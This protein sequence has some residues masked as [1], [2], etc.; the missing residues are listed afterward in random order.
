MNAVIL[1]LL[2]WCPRPAR[3]V[4]K[5]ESSPEKSRVPRPRDT[6][7]RETS[8]PGSEQER[9]PRHPILWSEQAWSLRTGLKGMGRA[10]PCPPVQPRRLRPLRNAASARW[11]QRALPRLRPLGQVLSRLSLLAA[12]L[13]FVVPGSHAQTQAEVERLSVN[14]EAGPEGAS[15]VIKADLKGQDALKQN[16]IYATRVQH[17]MAVARDRLD[18]RMEVEVDVI[19]GRLE[20]LTF[21]LVGVGTV[22]E[23]QADGLKDWSVRRD[24]DGAWT[25]VLRFVESDKPTK[26]AKISLRAIT[27]Y[28][29][30]SLPRGLTPLTLAAE[31]PALFSGY[32]RLEGAS[33]L[34]TVIASS[35]GLSPIEL[36]FAPEAMREPVDPSAAEPRIFRFFG[37]GYTASLDIREADP[38]ARRVV[39]RG[40]TLNGVLDDAGASFLIKATAAVKNPA[41][42]RVSLLSGGYAVTVINDHPEWKPVYR[43]GVLYL[44]FEKPGEFPIELNFDA[45]VTEKDGWSQV[46]F[47]VATAALQ[48]VALH[49][50]EEDTEFRF[51]GAAQPTRVGQAF[52]SHLPPNGR[53]ALAWKES[54]PETEGRLFYAAEG[55]SQL[56]ISP[57]LL[58][59]TMLLEFRVMQGELNRLT[60]NVA[61]SGEVTRVQG[62]PVLS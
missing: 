48:P 55:F 13:I 27:E 19:Q 3:R 40:F 36:G 41:G 1:S 31:D 5:P 39:L 12:G 29:T 22:K 56:T 21:S 24:I 58:R 7:R 30:P 18:H 38:E 42:G 32:V 14:G 23:V 6:A 25:L 20:E 4:R 17:T 33:D 49:G 8:Q 45:A 54:K 62:A 15:L 57:G 37:T 26:H 50:L 60:L 34:E 16:L 61:G 9:S 59:Q 53:V 52:E 51:E 43:D 10:A 28:P 46:D 44:Q 47:S 2:N 11:G 35:T